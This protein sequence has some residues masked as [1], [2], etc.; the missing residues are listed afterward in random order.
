M[1]LD[2]I[3]NEVIG[4]VITT[5]IVA[6]G[7]AIWRLRLHRWVAK[8]RLRW[9]I[10]SAP[11]DAPLLSVSDEAQASESLY[12]EKTYPQIEFYMDRDELGHLLQQELSEA[13]SMDAIWYT[14]THATN[15]QVFDQSRPM[16]LRRLILL[17]PDG[18]AIEG[19]ALSTKTT[20][21]S[22]ASQIRETS[23]QA[24]RRGVHVMWFDGP[25]TPMVIG[26]PTSLEDAWVRVE[27]PLHFTAHRPGFRIHQRDDPNLVAW[28]R[29]AFSGM[30]HECRAITPE[31]LTSLPT[32]RP[33]DMVEWAN[34]L[35]QRE[36]ESPF[37]YI[38]LEFDITNAIHLDD[39]APYFE[40]VIR[41]RYSGT[42][43]LR[44][45]ESCSGKLAWNGGDFASEPELH[46]LRGAPPLEITGP[47][48]GA[49]YLR[50][51]LHGDSRRE[52]LKDYAGHAIEFYVPNLNISL[53]MIAFSGEVIYDGPL[54]IGEYMSMPVKRDKDDWRR[55]QRQALKERLRAYRDAMLQDVDQD[56]EVRFSTALPIRDL[57]EDALGAPERDRFWDADTYDERYVRLIDLLERIEQLDVRDDW[58]P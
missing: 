6:V 8:Q 38:H 15:Y 46:L 50:Q 48:G 21:E 51:Y 26:N 25:I 17:D 27:V 53:R 9:P 24:S 40:I 3:A 1:D 55:V 52:A 11:P 57:L 45:G 58:H 2:G 16:P 34:A 19:L 10:Y 12:V 44:I 42:M 32:S 33:K 41:V 14:G 29:D 31:R 43:R 35:L 5:L 36:K 18:Y 22:L 54:R 28:A 49:I 4:G 37:S 7:V 20:V 30:W 56:D 13:D 23:R 39:P 47:G